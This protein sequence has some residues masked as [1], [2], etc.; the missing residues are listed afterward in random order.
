MLGKIKEFNKE[1]SNT[2]FLISL[3]FIIIFLIY[4]RISSGNVEKQCIMPNDVT[5]NYKRYSY[6]IKYEYGDEKIEL[7]I[8]RYNNKYLIEKNY[9]ESK[10]VFYIE[11]TDLLIKSNEKY[12]KYNMNIIDDMDNKY[13][14][15]DYL[16]ELSENSTLINKNEIDC[17]VN[18]KENVTICIN[19]DK[20]IE[21]TKNDHKLTYVVNTTDEIS[22]FNVM[23]D[24]NTTYSEPV[25]EK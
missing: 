15:L 14:M 3:L 11:Y 13:I 25:E 1:F 7:Y 5:K 23:I 24:K 18:S 8:K 12:I 9:N 20:S 16:N 21:L 4:I 2:F 22:D 6:N 10:N 19:L 17:Y